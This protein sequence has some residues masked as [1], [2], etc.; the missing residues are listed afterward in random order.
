MNPSLS[1]RTKPELIAELDRVSELNRQEVENFQRALHELQVYQEEIQTQNRQLLETQRL[2]AD[3]RDRYADL[4]EFAPVAYISLDSNGVILD[5]NLTGASLLG[6]E[7]M[8]ILGYPFHHFVL[9][10]DRMRWLDHLRRCR[11][12]PSSV[13][14]EIRLQTAEGPIHAQVHSRR[15]LGRSDEPLL[16]TAIADLTI[17]KQA[18]AEVRRLNAELEDRVRER[19]VQL[20]AANEELRV[21]SRRKDEFLAML[22][23]ELRN[24]LAAISGGLTLLRMPGV[25]S[26]EVQMAHDILERQVHNVTRLVN[27]LLEVGR[28]TMNKI[29]LQ[30]ER[31]DLGEVVQAAVQ[32][33]QPQIDERGHRLRLDLPPRP[34]MVFADAA[35][36]EQVVVN[37]VSNAAKYTPPGGAIDVALR[38]Q[39]GEVAI[40]VCDNGIGMGAELLT[41]AFDL[42]VQGETSLDRAEG[43]LGIGLTLVRRLVELH[44]GTVAAASE[45]SG[46]GSRFIVRLPATQPPGQGKRDSASPP[47]ADSIGDGEQDVSPAETRVLIVEDHRDTADSLS[48]LLRHWGYTVHTVYDGPAGVE[49]ASEFHPDAAIVDIGLP[50][51][52]GY[53]VAQKLQESPADQRPMLIAITGYGRDVDQKRAAEV[54]FDH[55]FAKPVD[56]KALR[57]VLARRSAH[58]DLRG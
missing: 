33:V 3:S 48:S 8:H 26:D 44:G 34:V 46:R 16:R 58:A 27:D 49:I 14:S 38:R 29:V 35:R 24:P 47:G 40:E 11:V 54:G 17:Q 1:D 43:G 41:R 30:R 21:A 12:G 4:Y 53:G 23:H 55:H 42:F 9:P 36:I 57:R 13:S 20:E 10:V 37:L 19:T 32:T 39:D 50:G 52:D 51:M 25:T 56:P 15:A 18:E 22:G 6:K 45:G 7:R 5:I 31:I 28:V 2:L